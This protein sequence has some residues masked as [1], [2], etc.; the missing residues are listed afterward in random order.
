MERPLSAKQTADKV[1][2]IQLSATD[3]ERK[4]FE[5]LEKRQTSAEMTSDLFTFFL[6]G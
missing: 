4:F 6:K 5:N 3:E 2:L 1:S